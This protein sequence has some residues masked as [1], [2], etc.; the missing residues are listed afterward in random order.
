MNN[1]QMAVLFVIRMF[2]CS[3]VR[4]SSL[5][6]FV[7]CHSD[8]SSFIAPLYAQQFKAGLLGGIVTSQVDGDT[9]SGYDKL[10]FRAGGFVT[11]R[12][13]GTPENKWS[14]SFEITYIQK[15]SKKIPHPAQGDFSEYK[16]KLNYAEVPVLLRYHFFLTDSSGNRKMKFALEGGIA[17][18]KLV[19][20]KEY[21]ANGQVSGGIP[22]QKTEYSYFLGLNYFF[23]DKFSFN[24]RSQY[25]IFPVRK[26]SSSSSYYQNW[27]YKF[28]KPGYYN[29]LIVFSFFI[30][31]SVVS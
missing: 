2:Y 11:S 8:Y 21:D 30:D 23:S 9:Y 29:N 24:I 27:T 1:I 14:A 22:F 6:L 20:S 26:I 25:S 4:H 5:I 16:L 13:F 19:Y 15:G 28:L 31:L 12:L 18:G 3:I 10:G 17:F 7:I